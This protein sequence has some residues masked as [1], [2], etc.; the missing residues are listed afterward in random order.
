MREGHIW[1][2]VPSPQDISIPFICFWVRTI[3]AEPNVFVI[4]DASEGL[5][6]GKEV[7]CSLSQ[8][9]D[10]ST[11]H[12]P[13]SCSVSQSSLPPLAHTEL[14]LSPTLAQSGPGRVRV[15]PSVG[16]Q[17][18]SV[19]RKVSAP[20]TINLSPIVLI[21]NTRTSHSLNS[22]YVNLGRVEHTQLQSDQHQDKGGRVLPSRPSKDLFICFGGEWV[23]SG[24]WRARVRTLES[25]RLRQAMRG[26]SDSV[27]RHAE[28]LEVEYEIWKNKQS[29]LVYTSQVNLLT[30][31]IGWEFKRIMPHESVLTRKLLYWFRSR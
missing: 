23:T 10:L 26:M 17:N 28:M 3:K 2:K 22:R 29:V 12:R 19:H 7:S 20:Y 8:L 21:H 11:S 16:Q 9:R 1:R 31:H 30:Q 18:Q 6:G 5:S 14:S 15:A 25:Q 13:K 4:R 27:Q 24:E